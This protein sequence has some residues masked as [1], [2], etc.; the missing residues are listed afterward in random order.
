MGIT[1]V[2][3]FDPSTVKN[4]QNIALVLAGGAISG[5]A[6]K[7][8]GLLAMERFLG[9]RS[10]NDFDTYVGISAGAFL[11]AP[12]AAGV[13]TLE[14]YRAILGQSQVI[15][16]F[17]PLHFYWPNF[18]EFVTKPTRFVKDSLLFGPSMMGSLVR[19]GIYKRR[20]LMRTLRKKI[21]RRGDVSWAD[22]IGPILSEA[23]EGK[24]T[25]FSLD[26]LPSA[27]F[28]NRQIEKYIREN[29]DRNGLPNSLRLLK[30]ERGVSLYIGATNV[31]TAKLDV[32][33]PDE[34]DSVTISQA[35][36]AS[37][38]IPG[39]FR[40]ARLG[41]RDYFDGGISRTASMS[42]A[43]AKGAD[44][45]IAYNPFRPYIPQPSNSAEKKRLANAGIITV[46]NQAVRTLLHTRL[47]IGVEKLRLDP[48]FKGDII[49]VEP[50]PTDQDFFH[51]NPLNFWSRTQAVQQGYTSVKE[52]LEA[53]YSLVAKVLKAHGI[54][55]DLEALQDT[56][57]KITAAQESQ[58]IV[59]VFR[60][61]EKPDKPK[62]KH[63]LQLVS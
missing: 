26:Y 36:Q 23:W 29:L 35:V 28:D 50:S 32:F 48:S 5:G 7:L 13:T 34:D 22:A 46:L 31:D 3:K 25:P 42:V 38:A 9:D 59:D 15:T 17:T 6:F 1:I 44:L 11:A 60:G 52:S 10:I 40:P 56:L 63:K 45:I 58:E 47:H 12:L 19:A 43:A 41:D 55:P 30:L 51:M 16:P 57:E 33:G 54:R 27:L 21:L 4:R 39:F 8:G 37:T 53:Q 14:L 18:E 62:G 20:A 24:K 2:N 49:L 61:D